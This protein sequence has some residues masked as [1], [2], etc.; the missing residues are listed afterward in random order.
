MAI[1]NASQS[2]FPVVTATISLDF[3]LNTAASLRIEA[4]SSVLT[5]ASGPF[6]QSMVGRG[7]DYVIKGGVLRDI[8]GGTVTG[9]VVWEPNSVLVSIAGWN[10]SAKRLFDLEVAGKHR[11]VTNLM[12]AESDLIFGSANPDS[13]NGLGGAD[14]IS[15]GG[16]NDVLGGGVG[17]DKLYGGAGDDTFVFNT[18]PGQSNFDR[19]DAFADGDDTLLFSNDVFT[20][21]G[22][23]GQVAVSRIAYGNAAFEADHRLIYNDLNGKLWYDPDGNGARAK[24]LVAIIATSRS[25][26]GSSFEVID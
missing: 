25:F 14:T 11:A 9:V 26:D 6:S 18:A 22:S 3:F 17:R 16:G 7:F 21:L 10:I 13:L 5:V 15:G 19:T 4:T 1:F 23:V 2:P 24:Q 12:F 8:V 20:R